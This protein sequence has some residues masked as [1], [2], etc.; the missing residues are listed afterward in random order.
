[1]QDHL[2]EIASQ[3]A[4]T[5]H[6]VVASNIDWT[7]I[8]RCVLRRPSN[9]GGINTVEA[10]YA[11]IFTP[12]IDEL[13]A[14]KCEYPKTI[15]YT[16]LKWCGFGQ[17]MALMPPSDAKEEQASE[18]SIADQSPCT[19]EEVFDTPSLSMVVSFNI[20]MVLLL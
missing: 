18:L 15:I 17:E 7:N 11:S 5:N 9:A 4:M 10:S 19:S 12:L 13:R 1:M 16:K 6:V 20:T 14:K 3:L 2:G 8:T